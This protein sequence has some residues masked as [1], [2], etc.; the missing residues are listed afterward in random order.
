[1]AVQ[2]FGVDGVGGV[3]RQSDTSLALARLGTRETFSNYST[4]DLKDVSNV[5]LEK[6]GVHEEAPLHETSTC[7]MA[8]TIVTAALCAVACGAPALDSTPVKKV[9]R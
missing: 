2:R 1:M 6:I 4:S 3:A 8:M 9:R 5:G 7:T